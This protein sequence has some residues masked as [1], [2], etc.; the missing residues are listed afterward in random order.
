MKSQSAMT[1]ALSGLTS[2]SVFATI[3]TVRHQYLML[4]NLFFGKPT[5]NL[6][7][8]HSAHNAIWSNVMHHDTSCRDY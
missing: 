6:L 3:L 8:R 1:T 5:P 4:H 7:R 2:D